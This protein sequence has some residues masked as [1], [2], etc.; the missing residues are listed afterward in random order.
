[1]ELASARRAAAVAATSYTPP[2][3]GTDGDVI[4]TQ[5]DK[6]FACDVFNRRT[7]RQ[8]L[9]KDMFKRL[10]RTIELGEPLDPQVADVVASNRHRAVSWASSSCRPFHP[11]TR[12]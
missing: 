12:R 3:S 1:M 5:I 8:R 10:M 7:M 6:Y 2:S 9:S 4:S 11:R